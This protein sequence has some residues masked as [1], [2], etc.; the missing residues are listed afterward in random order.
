[1]NASSAPD[2]AIA[3]PDGY[4]I[5]RKDRTNQVGGGIAFIYK[6]SIN[7]TT[8]TED[9]LIAAEHMHFQIHTDPRTT[10]R[11]TL[12]YRPPGPS[13]LFSESITDFISPHA[14]ASPYYILLGD[15]NF[16]LEQNND[17]NTT[18]LLDNLANL[19]LKQLV[20]T[21]THITGHTLD[22]IFSASNHVSFS[23]STEI[24][25]TDHRCVHFTF[26]RKTHHP[27]TQ[28]IARRPWN[29]ISAEQ[30][31][32]TLNHN[33]PAITSD[34]NNAALR[35]TQWVTNCADNLAPLRRHPSQTNA[36]KPQW[37]T[38]ALKN[39]KRTC[40]TLQKTW[41]K[42]HTAENMSALKNAT[43]EHHQLTRTTKRASFKE[44]LDKNTHNSK[45]LFNIVNKLSNPNASSN[46]ITPSQELCNSLATFFHRKI[47]E[48]HDS[49]GPQIPPTTTELTASAVTLNT[50]T[51]IS[52]E[53]TKT[54][55]NT[56]HSSAP[57]DP[58]PYYIFN[59]ADAS[60]SPYLQT[61]FNSSLAS[62][63]FPESWKHA[64]VNTLLKKTTADPND[65]K[66]FRPISLLPFLA[67][68]I[69]KTV[70]K[71]LT[72]FL[73]DNNLLD[74]SQSGFRANHSTETALLAVTD[75]IRTL[76]DNGE[77]TT[78]ILLDLSAAFDTVCHRTL[79][80]R[81]RS[82]GILGQA[83]D[84]IISFLSDRSQRVYLPPFSSEPTEIICGAPQ[85]SSLSP[86]LFNVY[87]SPL[88]NIA[89]KHNI[90]IISY[91]DDTQLILSLT[92][93]PAT[94]KTNLH[95]GMKDVAEWM[96]LSR[97]KLN[98]DKTE[99]L[100][101]GNSP[102]AWADSWW[103]TSLG[104]APTPSDHARNLGFILDPLL[105]MTKQVNAVSSS[106]FL[107]LCML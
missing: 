54:T 90:N 41:R 53:E 46:S 42:E 34:A 96:K 35:L 6:S 64:E 70:N 47:T 20:N 75:D 103:P 57:S 23:H 26:R 67:K 24:H 8:S 107:T 22:P 21:P 87:M 2:I 3:I 13:A 10:L 62:A 69:E 40:Q 37:F 15:L 33:Q 48:L 49:F 27:R 73:E 97:L 18:T 56:I 63:T 105:T 4:K 83:L 1:M 81:L 14:I 93:D 68:V 106:C 52:A 29:K 28:P 44:R 72:N 89:R 55:M 12:V 65:L 19:G 86:T 32:S 51:P 99:I 102:S 91:A 79:I 58:C 85:C 5:T 11:G 36:R 43:R 30:L 25:W 101:L 16:H 71:Q 7:I 78:L 9:T 84:W 74:P 94:A 80:T 39:S 98:S 17:T 45:E 31:L 100:I 38:D 92:K 95:D 104:T 50:W 88:A 61:I 59:Q 77:T 66:N 60:I 82:T 76:L